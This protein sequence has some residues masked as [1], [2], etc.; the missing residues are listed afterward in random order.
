MDEKFLEGKRVILSGN[1]GNLGP[2]W[3]GILRGW[4]A[5]VFG[6]DWD[7]NEEAGITNA[8]VRKL[9]MLYI[10]REKYYETCAACYDD[11]SMRDYVPDIIINN[12]AIDVPP[13]TQRVHLFSDYEQTIATNL[14]GAINLTSLFIDDM[15]ASPHAGLIINIGSIQGS[16]AADWRNYPAGF[17]KPLGYN[18]S[19]AGLI[20]FTRS[21]AVQYGRDN[22]RSVCLSFAAVDTGKFDKKFSDNFM[23]CLPLK[24]FICIESLQSALRFAISC[25][26][27]TGQQ[28]LIDSGYTAW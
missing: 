10:F 3:E 11:K 14:I 25:P 19:K 8:D 16:V 21:L 26:E 27:L 12:A 2:V 23:N 9:E 20:Q 15:R 4:G 28:V 1:K 5:R 22:I 24:R 6:F 7:R 18:V 13:N 17:E